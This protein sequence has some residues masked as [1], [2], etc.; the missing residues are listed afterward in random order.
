M[1]VLNRLLAFLLSLGL[2]LGL[3]LVASEVVAFRV[4]AGWVALDW[5]GLY[6]WAS[7]ATWGSALVRTIGIGLTIVALLLLIAQFVR[8]AP[9]RL[10][11][12]PV[13]PRTDTALT[14]RGLARAVRNA[15]VAVD[16][17][18]DANVTVRKRRLKIRAE[19][20][21]TTAAGMGPVRDITAA[22]QHRLDTLR[23][24]NPPI[25]YVRLDTEE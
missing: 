5:P 8:R 1:R 17:V 2:A 14:R 22:A 6:R 9:G 13:D 3:L 16:G 4:G 19:V 23:L 18:R 12:E 20:V 11:L 7:G 24:I 15:V 25:P 21:S 10:R